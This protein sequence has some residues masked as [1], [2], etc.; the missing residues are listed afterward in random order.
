MVDFRALMNRTPE[1]REA[2][3]KKQEDRFKAEDARTEFMLK[4]LEDQMV[5][6]FIENSF[7]EEFIPS[8][9]ARFNAGIPLSEKQMS[10]LEEL[11]EQY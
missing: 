11:F 8:V 7:A 5:R 4:K 6:G 3:R 2:S 9:R 10:T 1:E